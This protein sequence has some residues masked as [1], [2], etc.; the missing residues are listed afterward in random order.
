MFVYL[1]YKNVNCVFCTGNILC[2]VSHCVHMFIYA[3]CTHKLQ[4][5]KQKWMNENKWEKIQIQEIDECVSFFP[6]KPKISS[7]CIVQFVC[8]CVFRIVLKI[9]FFIAIIICR[10]LNVILTN[11]WVTENDGINHNLNKIILI[12]SY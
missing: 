7:L 1:I 2:I 3:H 11:V 5:S 12:L 6:F 10:F 9:I 8:V 4:C